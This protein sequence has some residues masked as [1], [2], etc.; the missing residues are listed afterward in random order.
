MFCE[1]QWGLIHIEQL[2]EENRLTAE[3]RVLH[4][5]AHQAGSEG[6]PGMRIARGLRLRSLRLGLAGQA[7]VVEFHREAGG[8]SVPGL[9]GLWRA[10]PVEYKRGRPKRD[11]CDEVQ[12]CAQALCLEEMFGCAVREGALYYGEPRRRDV[13]ELGARLRSQVE[14]LARKMHELHHAGRTPVAVYQPKC[15]SCSLVLPCMPRVI[16]KPRRVADYLAEALKGGED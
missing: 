12:L 14:A 8:A 9:D 5:K 6:R 3:G 11:S 10:H 13:V 2:W 4:E 15:R 7:D 16:A 1:R